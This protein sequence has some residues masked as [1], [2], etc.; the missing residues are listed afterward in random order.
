MPSCSPARRYSE[1]HAVGPAK[2]TGSRDNDAASRQ[3][4]ELAIQSTKTRRAPA[5]PPDRR[6]RELGEPDEAARGMRRG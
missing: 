4:E 1:P 5:H 3:G 2:L 6:N